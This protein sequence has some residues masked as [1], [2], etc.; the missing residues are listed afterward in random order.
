MN[1]PPETITVL[2][3]SPTQTFT[4]LVDKLGQPIL[5][6]EPKEKIGFV[7][8]TEMDEEDENNEGCDLPCV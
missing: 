3:R 7:V 6:S 8:F 2:E 5:R 1:Y 4:G